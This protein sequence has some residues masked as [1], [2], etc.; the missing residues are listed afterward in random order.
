MNSVALSNVVIVLDHPQNLVNIA[1]V[2]RAMK[3]MGLRRLRLVSPD[4]FDPWRIEGIAHRSEDVVKSA[5]IHG[6]LE[7]A[8]ADCVYVL[9]AT[10]R[11]RT[12]HRNYLRPRAAAEMLISKAEQGLVS[13][14]FG[15]E[16]RGLTNEGLDRCDAAVVIPTDPNYSSMNL[17]HA[18][19]LIAYELLLAGD[20]EGQS[21][22]K[23]KRSAGVATRE[24]SEAMLT[25]LE[26][27]LGRI[28]FF[29]ARAAESV[30]RTFRTLLSRAKL[31]RQEAGLVKA[32]GFEIGNY[33]D[34]LHA[35]RRTGGEGVE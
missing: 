7:E 8:V 33:L 5:T 11:P 20:G 34:R 3:N 22:P 15:R 35:K 19:L 25:A 6:T 27:G 16:D 18:C 21:L 31:D 14:V 24:E 30:M 9:G 13:V 28:E 10:A 4:E 1:G 29:K 26:E 2:V 23:G 32:V 17:A 12:A